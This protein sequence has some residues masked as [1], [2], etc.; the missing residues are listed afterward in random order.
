MQ[1]YLVYISYDGTNYAGYQLQKNAVTVA[2]KLIEALSAVFGTFSSFHGCSRTDSGVHAREFAFS[3]KSE[4]ILEEISVVKALN[5]NL[6]DDISVRRCEYVSDNFHARY[7]V[8]RKEYIYFL[9][10]GKTRD[11]FLKNYSFFINRDLDIDKMNRAAQSLVGTH[12]FSAFCASGGKIEDKTRTIYS[13]FFEKQEELI[14]FRICGNGFLYKMV[15]LIVGTLIYISDGKI[16]EDKITEMLESKIL[17][18][19]FA[20]PSRGLFLNKVYYEN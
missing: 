7:D 13:A 17:T 14:V 4:K 16:D 3:F 19:G 18:P 9:Y 12:D 2:G 8:V 20:A 6:P 10:T 5:F 11:P 1:N 15:R